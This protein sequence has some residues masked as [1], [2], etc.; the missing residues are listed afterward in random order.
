MNERPILFSAPMVRAI[1]RESDPKTVTRRTSG[2]D[3][4]NES[5]CRWILIDDLGKPGHDG[6]FAFSDRKGI[7]P[8]VKIRCP[9]GVAGDRLYTRES[10][11]VL[12][13]YDHRKPRELVGD[14][15]EVWYEADSD[16]PAGIGKLRPGIFMPRWASRILLEV[17][18]V[19]P[20]RLQAI[21]E[22]DAKAEGIESFDFPVPPDPPEQIVTRFGTIGYFPKTEP[23]A[24]LAFRRLWESINGPDSWAKNPWVWRV[25]FRR[26]AA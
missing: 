26:I 2:L 13:D 23:T 3:K 7:E 6:M 4:I 19:R 9:Y 14:W 18:S 15:I 25:E 22:E 17:V 10:Y 21:P 5:P 24:A 16:A 1:L 11:R 8:T 12:A 20:D